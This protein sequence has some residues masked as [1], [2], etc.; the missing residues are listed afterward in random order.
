MLH[1]GRYGFART[2]ELAITEVILHHHT[3]DGY[4]EVRPEAT[5]LDVD[6]HSNTWLGAWSKADE[7]GVVLPVGVLSRTRL[8]AHLDFSWGEVRGTATDVLRHKAV[9]AVPV[10]TRSSG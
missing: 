6:S 10:V 8:T 9:G 3:A 4:A 2:R 5:V 1:R 7:G